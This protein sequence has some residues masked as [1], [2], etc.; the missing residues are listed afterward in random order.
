[1]FNIGNTH[2]FWH[3]MFCLSF[4]NQ[5]CLSILN[6][7]HGRP[8]EK[9][10]PQT[11]SFL[12]VRWFS[13]ITITCINGSAG[14]CLSL[15]VIGY[16]LLLPSHYS[17]RNLVLMALGFWQLPWRIIFKVLLLFFFMTVWVLINQTQTTII[18][19]SGLCLLTHITHLEVAISWH[20]CPRCHL[21]LDLI[22]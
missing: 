7:W 3:I 14:F 8:E 17:P 11:S 16:S 22:L 21:S 20:V 19:A 6:T 13:I 1:M 18:S 15:C 12:Q 4:I 5:V 10:N 2:G 9:W